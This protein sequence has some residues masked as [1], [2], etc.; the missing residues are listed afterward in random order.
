MGIPQACWMVC[1]GKSIYEW[2][3]WG[4]HHFRKPLYNP[5][6]MYVEYVGQEIPMF[7]KGL[8]GCWFR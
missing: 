8:N 7:F 6:Y 5:I 2:M 1:D 4:Y 3:T